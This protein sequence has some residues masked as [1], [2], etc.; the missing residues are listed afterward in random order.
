MNSDDKVKKSSIKFS[1]DE[2]INKEIKDE[3]VNIDAYSYNSNSVSKKVDWDWK[4]LEEQEIERQ[5][6]PRKKINEPKTPYE[7]YEGDDE[8]MSKI[9]EI[10]KV[11]PTVINLNLFVE[12]NPRHGSSTFGNREK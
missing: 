2:I 3:Q 5:L 1:E 8:Y 6:N 12:R 7:A 11:Q 9:N 10:N 4:S